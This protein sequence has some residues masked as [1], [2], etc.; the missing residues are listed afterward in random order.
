MQVL[1]SVD[2]RAVM[3][4]WVGVDGEDISMAGTHVKPSPFLGVPRKHGCSTQRP[5]ILF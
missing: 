2:G 1:I 5:D 3:S 4:R